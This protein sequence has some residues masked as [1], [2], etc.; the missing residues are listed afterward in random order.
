MVCFIIA[1]MNKAV[2]SDWEKVE[3]N[4]NNTLHSIFNQTDDNFRVYVGYTDMPKLYEPFDDRLIMIPCNTHTPVERI[5]KLRDRGWKLS[6]CANAI[7]ND[8]SDISFEDGGVFVF[9]VDADDLVNKHIAEYANSHS[10]ANGFKSHKAY[11]H[12]KGRR[13]L[14]I[15]PYF[16][17]TMNVM[18]L[19]KSDLIAEMPDT[20]LCFDYATAC[21]LHK[22]PVRWTDHEV[23]QQ[24]ADLGRPLSYF[25]FKSTIYLVGTG[26]NLSDSDP[27]NKKSSTKRFHPV[28]FMRKISPFNK[29]L[30][31]RRIKQDFGIQESGFNV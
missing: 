23:E 6:A 8:L 3:R 9:P 18:K 31:T 16:G 30:I 26:D 17:G 20:S 15:T 19:Y 29:Q 5:E 22:S 25:P 13:Y 11:M 2:A 27:N 24:F 10:D 14:D 21:I 4:F 12:R 1:L 7:Y 28:A